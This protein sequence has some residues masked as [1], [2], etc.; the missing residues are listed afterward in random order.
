[1]TTVW[2]LERVPDEAGSSRATAPR[3]SGRLPGISRAM[4]PRTGVHR[5]PREPSGSLPHQ[6]ENPGPGACSTRREPPSWWPSPH[7][8]WSGPCSLLR[9]R[10]TLAG[11]AVRTRECSLGP[12]RR[13]RCR[14]PSGTARC[15]SEARGRNVWRTMTPHDGG[16]S[17]LA[18]SPQAR[19]SRPRCPCG[20]AND[21]RWGPSD[22]RSKSLRTHL[23]PS[24]PTPRR[25][26]N[27]PERPSAHARRAQRTRSRS[28]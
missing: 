10:P 26:S 8:S 19:G 15:R 25:G 6:R 2:T 21:C 11:R 16:M 4:R 12:G 14:R 20:S 24:Q 13:R 23:K 3:C 7:R 9:C 17:S 18:H 1:M 5:W 27:G 22:R 28:R